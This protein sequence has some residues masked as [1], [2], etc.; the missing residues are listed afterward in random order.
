M[1]RSS[2]VTGTVL[3]LLAPVAATAQVPGVDLKLLPKIGGFAPINS[4]QELDG[5]LTRS[6]EPSL[7]LGLGLELDVPGLPGFRANLDY[8]SSTKL[9]EEGGVAASPDVRVIALVGDVVLRR[10]IGVLSP[11]LLLGAGLKWYDFP[12][13]ASLRDGSDFT[14]HIGAGLELDLEFLG[15]FVEV[16]DYISSF[17]PE[18]PAT[19]T[20]DSRFQND[21]FAMV[22][23]KVGLF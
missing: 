4:L 9:E 20:A 14:G 6:L 17:T 1:R 18:D 10:G 7:A 23:V 15:L 3:V 22:G 19:D 21:I 13:E 12:D 2:L 11:Y 8:A 5:G 16:S